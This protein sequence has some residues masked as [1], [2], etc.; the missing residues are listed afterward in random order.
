MQEVE[1]VNF[2]PLDR[3]GSMKSVFTHHNLCQN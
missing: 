2:A 3:R 1:N